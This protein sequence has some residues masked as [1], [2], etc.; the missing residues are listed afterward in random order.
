MRR[1]L[2][3]WLTKPNLSHLTQH[4]NINTV[5]KFLGLTNRPIVSIKEMGTPFGEMPLYF[6][7]NQIDNYITFIDKGHHSKISP[8]RY[9]K[10]RVNLVND[11]KHY[12]RHKARLVADGHLTDI[13]LALVYSGVVRLRGI[14]TR[15]VLSRT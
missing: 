15:P 10:I 6:E 11:V 2:L 8:P 9:K 1:N 5:M 14:S 7:L 12:G 13:P 4:P 3:T